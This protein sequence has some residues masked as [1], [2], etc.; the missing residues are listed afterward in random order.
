MKINRRV[1]FA[2]SAGLMALAVACGSDDDPASGS[3]PTAVPANPTATSATA[4]VPTIAPDSGGASTS[5]AQGAAF[6]WTV[7]TVD[8]GTKPALALKSDGTPYVAYMLEAIPGFVKTASRTGD[9]WNIDTVTEDYFY[10]PLDLAIGPD[11]VPHIAFHDHQ[12][13]RFDSAKGDA[14]HAFLE[15]DVWKLE[16]AADDGHDGWDNRI[17]V[18]SQNVVHMTGIDPQE[19]NG[20]GVEYYRRN[21]DGS[22]TVEDIGS[23]KLTYQFATSLALDPDGNPH[24]TF[25]NQPEKDLALSSRDASGNWTVTTVDESGDTGL[26]AQILIDDS[27]RFHISYGSQPRS[28]ALTVKYATRGAGETDWTITEIDTLQNFRTGQTGARNSTSIALDSN[29]NPVIAYSDQDSVKIAVLNGTAWTTETIATATD[30]EFGQIVSLKLDADD[31]AHVVFAE[32]T[33]RSPLEGIVKYAL[34]IRN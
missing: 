7:E 31:N 12:D 9:Q 23:G 34:G 28:S 6:A 15:G 1:V 2:A 33:Q 27:G 11:D 25:F 32:T 14:V 17:I 4:I 16:I 19:F 21:A 22:W 30:D 26:F 29:G 24:V 13:T 3:N 5:P 18:D 20:D 8:E 10:G